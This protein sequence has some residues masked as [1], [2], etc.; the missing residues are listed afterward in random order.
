MI[1]FTKKIYQSIQSRPLSIAPN[2]T[3]HCPPV[4]EYIS[5]MY[6]VTQGT[7]DGHL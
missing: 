3:T 5:E 7:L 6:G 2:W 4:A 1:R